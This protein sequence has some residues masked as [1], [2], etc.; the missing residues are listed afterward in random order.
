MV[1]MHV[2]IYLVRQIENL[3]MNQELIKK[4][5]IQKIEKSK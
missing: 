3:F 2:N 4:K 1:G 5:K